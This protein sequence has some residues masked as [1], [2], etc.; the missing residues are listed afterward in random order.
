MTRNRQGQTEQ[1]QKKHV[2]HK[3]NCTYIHTRYTYAIKYYFEFF[4]LTHI[5]THQEKKKSSVYILFHCWKHNIILLY[6][7]IYL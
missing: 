7:T 5:H 4:S 3:S 1:K 6:S 2:V